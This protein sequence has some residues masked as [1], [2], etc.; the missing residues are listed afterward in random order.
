DFD[1]LEKAIKEVPAFFYYLVNEYKPIERASRLWLDP[2]TFQTDAAKKMQA[3]AR[4]QLIKA[5]IE[6]LTDYFLENETK[7]E[8]YFTADQFISAFGRNERWNSSW[9]ARDVKK[10]FN[11]KSYAKRK[12][13]PFHSIII[14]SYSGNTTSISND[15]K[16]R[17]YYHFTKDEIYNLNEDFELPTEKTTITDS[18]LEKLFN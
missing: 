8:V 9:F 12:R 5:I 17:R 10:H 18:E 16:Q 1:I 6:N 7:N 11:K 15:I 4:P 13:N 3:N 2:K 14:S